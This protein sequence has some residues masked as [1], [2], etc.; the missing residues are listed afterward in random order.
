[1]KEVEMNLEYIPALEELANLRCFVCVRAL[2][3]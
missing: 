3:F 2:Q 1:M